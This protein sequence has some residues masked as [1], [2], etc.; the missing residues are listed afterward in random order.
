LRLPFKTINF[1][2]AKL[3]TPMFSKKNLLIALGLMLS[4]FA[5]AQDVSYD[6]YTLNVQLQP[7]Y[8]QYASYT[9]F[10]IAATTTMDETEVNMN[11]PYQIKVGNLKQVPTSS[12]FHVVSVLRRLGGKFTNDI[13]LV[14]NIYLETT[15]YDRYGNKVKSNYENR[16]D[17]VVNFDKALSK[18]E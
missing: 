15:I 1:L 5:S 11:L 10:D 16:E 3:K 2:T 12:D 7:A 9:T 13:S 17:L 6:E 18:E 14:A 8:P 4:Q